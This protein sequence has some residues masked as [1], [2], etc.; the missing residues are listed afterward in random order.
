MKRRKTKLQVD[1]RC[2]EG[3]KR[4]LLRS[5]LEP[6]EQ[7]RLIRADNAESDQKRAYFLGGL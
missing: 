6:F 7:F 1:C 5:A 4:V 2:G 3:R